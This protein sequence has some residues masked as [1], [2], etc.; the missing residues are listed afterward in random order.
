MAESLT[1]DA[2]LFETRLRSI[3]ELL[4]R[5]AR[6]ERDSKLNKELAA[7]AAQCN[8]QIDGLGI[9]HPRAFKFLRKPQGAMT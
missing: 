5:Q 9:R 3:E 2:E 6:G 1:F 7:L 4:N 8:A